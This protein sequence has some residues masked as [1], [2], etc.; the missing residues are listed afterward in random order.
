MPCTDFPESR[1]FDK[2]GKDQG[3]R[4]IIETS[5]SL[6][7]HYPPLN[8]TSNDIYPNF[9]CIHDASDKYIRIIKK[10]SNVESFVLQVFVPTWNNERTLARC[11]QSIRN[12]IPDGEITLI[13]RYSSD[14]TNDIAKEFNANIRCFAGNRGRKRQLMCELAT[15][16]WFVMVDSDIYLDEFWF[17]NI[18]EVRNKI[19]LVDDRVGAI[20]GLNLPMYEPY[21]SW[22][23]LQQRRKKFPDKNAGGLNT[24]NIL[25]STDVIKDFK[26]SLPAT[27][28]YMMGKHIESKGYNWYVTDKA[29]AIHDNPDLDRHHRE[30]GAALVNTGRLPLWKLPV[31]IIELGIRVFLELIN[32][33]KPWRVFAAK[34]YLNHFIGAINSRKYLKAEYMKQ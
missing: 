6:D 33:P 34:T 12:S 18:I 29:I 27:E 2:N 25:L 22:C 20:Q 9:A 26:C 17:K 19:L 8:S 14:R 4:T 3:K 31:R 23:I 15:Q 21:R 28:D 1:S 10:V 13:D 16:D 32:T 7:I 11:L 30:A 24:G 5:A